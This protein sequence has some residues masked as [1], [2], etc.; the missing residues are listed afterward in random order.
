MT[1]QLSD[2]V[3]PVP[4]GDQP[5]SQPP[6]PVARQTG[7]DEGGRFVHGN[8]A[9]TGRVPG[10]INKTSALIKAGIASAIE[11]LSQGENPVQ[12]AQKLARIIESWSNARMQRLGADAAVL[13]GEEFDRLMAG[14][15]KAA[16][17]QLRLAEYRFPKL[18]RF[19]YVGDAPKM[20][21]QQNN[22]FRLRIPPSPLP[23]APINVEFQ[24]PAQEPVIIE[25]EPARPATPAAT[26][27]G[28]PAASGS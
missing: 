27:G 13:S 15:A 19:D 14:L 12:A 20:T 17:I 23:M 21:V 28:N 11:T 1:E 18:T 24:P 16:D 3:A 6:H 5:A 25:H 9:G 4:Q 10:S 2:P 8:R 7:R 26:N 22:V